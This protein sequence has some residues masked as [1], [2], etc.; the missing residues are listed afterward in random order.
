MMQ[1]LD[2]EPIVVLH[3]GEGKGFRV[4]LSGL[5]DNFQLHTLLADA[6]IG[7][8][9]GRWLRGAR[10]ARAEVAAARDGAVREGCPGAHGAFNLWTWRGLKADGTL[11]DPMSGSSHWIWNE[12]VP[13]DIPSFDGERVVLLGPPPVPLHGRRPPRGARLDARRGARP[14]RPHH[15]LRPG[16]VTRSSP[17]PALPAVPHRGDD[18]TIA[19]ALCTWP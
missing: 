2:D 9:P 1:V 14:P 17:L 6:L 10:P 12:G 15:G 8:F 18:A 19:T 16:G 11:R 3:P 5:A 7:Q 4:R 13:A